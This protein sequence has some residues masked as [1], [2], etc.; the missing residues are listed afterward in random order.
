MLVENAEIV[1]DRDEEKEMFE[2][3]GLTPKRAKEIILAAKPPEEV[4]VEDI[5]NLPN[6]I[7]S[8]IL[9]MAP[10]LKMT[11]NELLWLVYHVAVGIGRAQ[12]ATEIEMK[13]RAMAELLQR[14][15]MGKVISANANDISGL[16]N[17]LRSGR[18]NENE[19]GPN[20]EVV[21]TE[22][23]DKKKKEKDA[24]VGGMFG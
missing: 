1:F 18:N 2:A 11:T 23:K 22:D 8:Q 17:A 5:T 15:G 19:D 6:K 4:K 21:P 7:M 10:K 24:S 3:F 14:A 13:Q 16:L 12:E 20:V 9:D